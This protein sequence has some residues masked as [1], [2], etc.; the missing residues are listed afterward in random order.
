MKKYIMFIL[1]ISRL[2]A[3]HESSSNE[4]LDVFMDYVIHRTTIGYSLCGEKPVAIEYLPSLSKSPAY[5]MTKIFFEMPGYHILWRGAEQWQKSNIRKVSNKYIFKIQDGALIFI[6]K[7]ET[8]KVIKKNLDLFQILLKTSSSAHELLNN[9]CDSPQAK[10]MLKNPVLAGVLFG[11]GRNNALA[12][13]HRIL[14]KMKN[15][16][17]IKDQRLCLFL[18]PG[19]LILDDGTNISENKKVI[20]CFE[21]SRNKLKKSFNNK[22]YLNTFMKLYQN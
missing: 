3:A 20:Q 1:L 22:N 8:L 14:R 18:R 15:C 7:K 13:S 12:F 16:N 10:N 21:D 6:N 2:G 9:L 4:E 11:Y 19:F 5:A 17:E